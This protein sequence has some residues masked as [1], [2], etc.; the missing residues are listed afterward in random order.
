MAAHN[1]IHGPT[2][3]SSNSGILMEEE[4]V[5][6]TAS[7]AMSGVVGPHK[8]LVHTL[9]ASG[10]GSGWGDNQQCT[11]TPST[12]QHA[13]DTPQA[14][15]SAGMDY[16]DDA[17]DYDNNDDEE[18]EEDCD[19]D[20]YYDESAE[21]Q[22]QR[23]QDMGLE[24]WNPDMAYVDEDSEMEE[25]EEEGG[26][27]G[28]LTLDEMILMRIGLETDQS[29]STEKLAQ[30]LGK[31]QSEV[32]Y[33]LSENGESVKAEGEV[34]RL[35]ESGKQLVKERLEAHPYLAQ[36]LLQPQHSWDLSA[37]SSQHSLSSEAGSPR[38]PALLPT[39]TKSGTTSK[40]GRPPSPRS[41]LH[42]NPVFK[43]GGVATTTAASLPAGRGR[44]RGLMALAGT[45][46]QNLVAGTYNVRDLESASFSL[47]SVTS[48]PATSIAAGNTNSAE[49]E[50][51]GDTFLD[52]I[53][54]QPLSSPPK[55]TPSS[56]SAAAAAAGSLHSASH[57]SA[58]SS[59]SSAM[60]SLA[61]QK[62]SK[63]GLTVLPVAR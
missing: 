17:D 23:L 61:L 38:K 40:F 30:A 9:G 55:I 47:P 41:L 8:S 13:P 57:G 7:P 48:T 49:S 27:G 14:Q 15:Q 21:G 34:W 62:Y 26:V 56:S 43:A 4:Q 18:L 63:E 54:W 6:D 36:A 39:P 50:K 59:S 25:E 22:S 42:N 35:T 24:L 10:S 52:S 3:Q 46:T 53:P 16:D 32:S 44:G 28:G 31:S 12:S 5:D 58:G 37:S 60:E 51:T 11:V 45:Q 20:D 1:F 2:L 33:V 19:Y 29:I